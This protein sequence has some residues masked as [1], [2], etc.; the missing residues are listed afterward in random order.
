MKI[1]DR[2]SKAAVFLLTLPIKFYR[3]FLS[4]LLPK[5]CKYYPTCSAYAL[6]ALKKHGVFKGL[7]LTVW[8]LLRCNPFSNGGV[9]FVPD[10]ITAEYLKPKKVR[11]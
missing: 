3:K 9:D 1:I 10:R 2:L 7:F 8:R 4:P 11:S 6:E 5:S